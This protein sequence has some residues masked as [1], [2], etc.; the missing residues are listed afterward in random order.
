ML[1]CYSVSQE[2]VDPNVKRGANHFK[3]TVLSALSIGTLT[4]NCLC[5]YII[6]TSQVYAEVNPPGLRS[7]VLSY[8]TMDI[9][10]YI[11]SSCHIIDQ[12]YSIIETSLLPKMNL[13]L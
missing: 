4:Y 11:M 5:L 3:L 13:I 9:C 8:H 1:C 10:F 6:A 12:T 2:F 7:L